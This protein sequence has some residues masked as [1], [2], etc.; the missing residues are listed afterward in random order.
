MR[1]I[2]HLSYTT[3]LSTTT[4]FSIGVSF[5]LV[6]V[7]LL[8]KLFSLCGAELPL[9]P[10]SK[11]AMQKAT[12]GD[13]VEAKFEGRSKFYVGA[14]SNVNADRT[15]DIIYDLGKHFHWLPPNRNLS[16]SS[17]LHFVPLSSKRCG[18]GGRVRA[19]TACP[20]RTGG[21]FARRRTTDPPIA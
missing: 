8:H 18:T 17:S 2:S 19:N 4:R 20:P 7:F 13:K 5:F 14:I 6:V 11:A 9:T 15:V 10:L 16:P 3:T 1:P 21:A 12:V